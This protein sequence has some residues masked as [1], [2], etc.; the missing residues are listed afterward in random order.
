MNI[1]IRVRFHLIG[2]AYE[3]W[4]GSV[5]VCSSEADLIPLM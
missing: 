2:A 3:E 4:R 1:R 5:G